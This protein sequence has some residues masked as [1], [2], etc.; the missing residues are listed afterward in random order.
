MDTNDTSNT[1][2]L[3]SAPKNFVPGWL[4]SLADLGEKRITLTPEQLS[5]LYKARFHLIELQASLQSSSNQPKRKVSPFP[6]PQTISTLSRIYI[7]S[8]SDEFDESY[9]R[10]FYSQFG[11]VR[12]VSMSRINDSEAHLGYGYVDF[13]FPRSAKLA[14]ELIKGEEVDGKSMIVSRPN[15]FQAAMSLISDF[16][17][18]KRRLYI[19]NVHSSVTLKDIKRIFEIFG[20]LRKAILMPDGVVGN[21]RGYG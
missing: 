17:A 12:D 19:S 8:V 10:L 1:D 21:H 3:S 6:C 13:I 16:G 15:S 4:T 7:S 20:S 18:S 11:L 2:S 14:Y 9:I 5:V